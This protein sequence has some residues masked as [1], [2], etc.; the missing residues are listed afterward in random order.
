MEELGVEQGTSLGTSQSLEA[1]SK[2]PSTVCAGC[3][4]AARYGLPATGALRLVS[5][6]SW[7]FPIIFQHTCEASSF[8][9]KKEEKNKAPNFA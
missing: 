2:W 5:F 9:I 7:A 6:P 8:D 3:G 1:G 4:R